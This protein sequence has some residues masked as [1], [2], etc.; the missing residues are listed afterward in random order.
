MFEVFLVGLFVLVVVGTG[1]VVL[2][3][4]QLPFSDYLAAVKMPHLIEG[5][6]SLVHENEVL[7]RVVVVWSDLYGCLV[8]DDWRLKVCCGG[9]VY[10]DAVGDVIMH[11]ESLSSVSILAH[12]LGHKEKRHLPPSPELT[13]RQIMEVYMQNEFE[14]DRLA[15]R[16]A[17][18]RDVLK[19]FL[20]LWKQ[21]VVYAEGFKAKFAFT[22]LGVYRAV[23]V[24]FCKNPT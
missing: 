12:E 4:A 8:T 17:S 21:S 1:K 18:R 6:A 5:P 24:V 20:P 23:N 11:C 19:D 16:Y 3:K 2:S 9:G 14:A 22:L 15:L 7:N 10:Y 13:P